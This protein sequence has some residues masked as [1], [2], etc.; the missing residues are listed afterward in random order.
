MSQVIILQACGYQV[1]VNFGG[2]ESFA[3]RDIVR[4]LA[5]IT[6]GYPQSFL[7]RGF[8]QVVRAI[9][10]VV[11]INIAACRSIEITARGDLIILRSPFG[12]LWTTTCKLV[13]PWGGTFPLLR[14]ERVGHDVGSD[15]S[16]YSDQSKA[17]DDEFK[18]SLDLVVT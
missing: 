6:F 12:T 1:I 15:P 8:V 18:L 16:L 2:I 5:K 14:E 7:S 17:Y 9:G 4:H 3:V 11:I 13:V 10:F